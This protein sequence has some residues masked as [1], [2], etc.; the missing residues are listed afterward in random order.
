MTNFWYD[1]KRLVS[2]GCIAAAFASFHRVF[3]A[4]ASSTG[5]SSSSN[6]QNDAKSTR[7]LGALSDAAF[8]ALRRLES[9]SLS[10]VGTANVNEESLRVMEKVLLKQ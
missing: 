5:T 10:K 6:M 3:P 4:A 1:F 9:T 8:D 7:N 2:S